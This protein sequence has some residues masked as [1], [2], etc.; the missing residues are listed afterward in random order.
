M[1]THLD[2]GNQIGERL[3]AARDGL[4]DDV[5]VPAEDLKTRLLD[6]RRLLK[7]HGREVVEHPLRQV[8]VESVP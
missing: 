7:A 2:H 3:A 8:W 6:G 4:D 1:N 5:L